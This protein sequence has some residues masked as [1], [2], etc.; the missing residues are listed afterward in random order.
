MLWF[1][2]ATSYSE[3]FIITQIYWLSLQIANL[4]VKNA[5]IHDYRLSLIIHN[6]YNWSD[7]L[8]HVCEY[9]FLVVNLLGSLVCKHLFLIG[10]IVQIC[11]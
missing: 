6:R 3:W 1:S 4:M 2:F 8:I 7:L 11:C 5:Q 10:K 9:L